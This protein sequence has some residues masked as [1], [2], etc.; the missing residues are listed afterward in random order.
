MACL[1]KAAHDPEIGIKQT[2]KQKRSKT[3]IIIKKKKE[4]ENL[5]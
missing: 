1:K 3:E 2:N 4:K 5:Q